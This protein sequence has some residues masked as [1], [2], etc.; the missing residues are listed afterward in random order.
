MPNRTA[1]AVPFAYLPK[2]ADHSVP[3][4]VFEV[5]RPIFRPITQAKTASPTEPMPQT[6]QE[7]RIWSVPSLAPFGYVWHHSDR[8]F[9]PKQL[10]QF[11]IACGFLCRTPSTETK[12]LRTGRSCLSPPP[13]FGGIQRRLSTSKSTS[14]S[15]KSRSRSWLVSYFEVRRSPKGGAHRHPA[16]FWA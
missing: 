11:T 4:E 9:W 3:F 7:R 8:T 14:K 16:H 15:R 1:C 2:V 13:L 6:A 5:S 12:N 10:I